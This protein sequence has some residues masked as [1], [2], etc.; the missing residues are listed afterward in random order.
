[1]DSIKVYYIKVDSIQVDSIKVD[2]TNHI[3]QH[4]NLL[5]GDAQLEFTCTHKALRVQLPDHQ[6][7]ALT[8]DFSSTLFH[9]VKQICK[10]LG[11]RHPEELSLLRTNQQTHQAH[12]HT[13]VLPTL[14]KNKTNFDQSQTPSPKPTTREQQQQQQQPNTE[15]ENSVS[16]SS[17]TSGTL[18]HSQLSNPSS[19]LL[20][21]RISQRQSTSSLEQPRAWELD[22]RDR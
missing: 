12:S 7:L 22:S 21:F 20:R 11:I 2:Y 16:S 4:L 5:Q 8:V 17:N 14:T 10:Q 19:S 1:M 15:E 18:N 9:S 3:C 6:V 13:T